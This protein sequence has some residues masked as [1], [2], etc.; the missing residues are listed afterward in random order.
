MQTPSVPPQCVVR[1]E[2]FKLNET[3]QPKLRWIEAFSDGTLQWAE[4]E[5]VTAKMAISLVEAHVALEVPLKAPEAGAKKKP[6]DEARWGLRITPTAGGRH[7]FL[8]CCSDEERRVWFE[9]LDAIAHPSVAAYAA[10]GG[11]GR[12]VRLS[13][14]EPGQPLGIDL[15]ADPG[16]PCVTVCGVGEHCA[17][18]GLL[19]GDVIVAVDTT[20]LRTMTVAHK[21]FSVAQARPGHVMTLRLAACNREVRVIKQAGISGL[22]LS[23]PEMGVG[24]LVQ[25]VRVGRGLG[26]LDLT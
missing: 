14:A 26:L 5:G 20:V 10:Q 3:G 9:A 12:V 22:T 11:Y 18:A 21:A 4:Q 25:K 15:G 7:Y 24:V 8:R 13:F 1:G 16:A 17:K 19:V 23:A 6:E 2:L